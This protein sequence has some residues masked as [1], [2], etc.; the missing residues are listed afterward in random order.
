MENKKGL[1]W[2]R[3]DFRIS[4]NNALVYASENHNQVSAVYIF[5]P[6]EYENNL[7]NAV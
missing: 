6:E 3:D 1:V 4:R 2:I 7:S 5:N